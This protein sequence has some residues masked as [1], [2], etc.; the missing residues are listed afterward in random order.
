MDK[1][2]EKHRVLNDSCN[3]LIEVVREP[4]ANELKQQLL[5]IN[6]RW[7]D[8]SDQAKDFLSVSTDYFRE[9]WV[10]KYSAKILQ[11]QNLKTWDF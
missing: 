5:L 7:K 11:Q 10:S 1:W 8:L 3:F 6:R 9:S 2:E 4:I